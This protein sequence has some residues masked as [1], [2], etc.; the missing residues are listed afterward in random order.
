MI[1]NFQLLYTRISHDLAGVAG[2]VYNGSELIEE[3]A[4]NLQD[5]VP[6]LMQSAER[7]VTR[8]KFFRQMFGVPAE[9]IKDETDAYLKT[10]SAPFVLHGVCETQLQKILVFLLS[11]VMIYGG[12]IF[13][14]KSEIC[15]QSARTCS[16][17]ENFSLLLMGVSEQ[18]TEQTIPAWAASITAQKEGI[19][20]NPEIIGDKIKIQILRK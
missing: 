17:P 20:L 1:S 7:L 9:K 11:S 18:A 4:E 16:F 8:L 12:E 6:M 19:V 10:L 2:A 3:S 13:V 14:S 5:A 15:G